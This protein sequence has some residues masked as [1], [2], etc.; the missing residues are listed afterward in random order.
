VNTKDYEGV[1]KGLLEHY[2]LFLVEPVYTE[3]VAAW[4]RENGYEEPDRDKP[5]KLIA[6]EEKGCRLVINEVV[7]ERVLNERIN[8]LMV[9][10]ALTNVAENKADRLDS[11][12]KKL[13]YLFLSEYATTLPDLEGDEILADEWVFGEMGKLGYF[14]E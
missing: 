11:S 2:C 14:D 12:K 5:L 9:R 13:A 7:P 4:C 10:S 8:A 3:S 6:D 1:V